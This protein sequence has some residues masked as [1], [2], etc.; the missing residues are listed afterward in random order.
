MP[1]RK[2][3]N[4]YQQ[5]QQSAMTPRYMERTVFA[6]AVGKLTQAQRNIEDYNA[7][8]D[9]LKFNQRLWTFIQSSVA[10]D[11]D[12]LPA[13]IRNDLLNL[14]LFIDRQ[15]IRALATPKE[16]NLRALIDINIDISRGLKQNPAGTASGTQDHHPGERAPSGAT[17][18]LMLPYRQ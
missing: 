8:A 4:A 13:E 2:A 11:S 10:D 9:A 16:A 14:S 3:L 6:R 7:Y 12:R 15:T 17:P 1:Y 5:A 18:K